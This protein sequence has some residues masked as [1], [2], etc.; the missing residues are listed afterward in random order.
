M[1]H[2]PEPIQR[3]V[4]RGIRPDTIPDHWRCGICDS[5]E[6]HVHVEGKPGRQRWRDYGYDVRNE[7]KP[8]E[9]N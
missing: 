8:H 1:S 9:E 6:P 3:L 5:Q 7:Q 2:A 4:A